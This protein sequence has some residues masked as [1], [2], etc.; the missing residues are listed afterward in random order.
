MD[1]PLR[2]GGTGHVSDQ[3]PAPLHR[4]M[5]EDQQADGQGPQLRPDR[6][7]RVRHGRRARRDM[8][9]AAGAPRLGQLV[10]H[11]FRRGGRDLL[12]LE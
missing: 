10:L 5:L 1:E 7:G 3:L 4:H 12:L 9:P 6:L 2:Y 8:G 11:P